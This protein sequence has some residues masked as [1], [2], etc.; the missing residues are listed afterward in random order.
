MHHHIREKEK[1]MLDLKEEF[2]RLEIY[3]LPFDEST[4][5]INNI[6]NIPKMSPLAIYR[7]L[8]YRI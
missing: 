4:I 8:L 2:S 1:I 6:Y 3:L 5:D 7:L